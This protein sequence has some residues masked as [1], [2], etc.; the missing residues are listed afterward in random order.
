[1]GS[2]TTLVISGGVTL[3]SGGVENVGFVMLV[4]V[5]EP[6]KGVRF[7]LDLATLREG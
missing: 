6:A 4:R 1:M 7:N 5:P 3:V 2:V